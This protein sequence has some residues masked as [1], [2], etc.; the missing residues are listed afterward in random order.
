MIGIEDDEN[1]EELEEQEDMAAQQETARMLLESG[2]FAKA[3]ELLE[4]T[5][6]HYPEF[7]PAYNNLA[8]AYFYESETEKAANLLEKILHQNPGNLH[9]LCNLAVFLYY[10]R[11][12]EEL[13]K[14]MTALEKVHPLLV[15]HR[16]K[17]G[18]TF[19]FTKDMKML[20]TG[21]VNYKR[22]AMKAM[23]DF[24]IGS[25]KQLIILVMCKWLTGLGKS[26]H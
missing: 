21:S 20:I 18:A 6:E 1:I 19:A 2:K 11:Q 16:Y 15:E 14:L 12:S 23:K 10:E 13:D 25:Q 9:A 8:L 7:W 5:I 22:M 4:K 17:L 3:I 24:I 26:W